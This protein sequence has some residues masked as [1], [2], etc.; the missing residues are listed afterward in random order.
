MQESP[1][2]NTP[3]AY[4]AS[5]PGYGDALANVQRNFA[6]G[7]RSLGEGIGAVVHLVKQNKQEQANADTTWDLLHKF[8]D[9]YGVPIKPEDDQKFHSLSLSAK[10]GMVGAYTTQI[11]A[12]MKAKM[13]QAQMAELR[14]RAGY[15]GDVGAARTQAAQEQQDTD[16][17]LNAL[18]AQFGQ[19]KPSGPDGT[20]T[21]NDI[22]SAVGAAGT[23]LNPRAQAA[24]IKQVFP[25]VMGGGA[26][27]GKPSFTDIPGT[28]NVLSTYGRQAFVVPKSGSADVQ[29]VDDGTGRQVPVLQGP[30]GTVTQLRTPAAALQSRYPTFPKGTKFDPDTIT[31]TLPDGSV[32]VLGHKSGGIDLNALFGGG[33]TTATKAAPAAPAAAVPQDH[34]DYLMQHPEA[35]ASFDLKYGDGAA[36]QYLNPPQQ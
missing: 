3:S 21:Q 29:M 9:Q 25:A 15:Y 34:I 28:S 13:D 35:A 27:P 18:F 30:K 7:N 19:M 32:S 5:N 14:A 33:T 23:K 1:V 2:L 12:S 8:G 31:A 4:A 26:A 20:W 24:L 6:E 10:K 17:G 22:V 11:G 16:A 36:E